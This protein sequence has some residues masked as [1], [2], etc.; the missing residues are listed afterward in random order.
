MPGRSALSQ[1]I[2]HLNETAELP[3][4]DRV[5]REAYLRQ[6]LLHKFMPQSEWRQYMR[7]CDE[8]VLDAMW[9]GLLEDKSDGET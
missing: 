7:P 6:P 5:A 9:S 3:E 4:A 8:A 2:D 1:F